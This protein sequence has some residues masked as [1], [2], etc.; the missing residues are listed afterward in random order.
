M[1][2][3]SGFCTTGAASTVVRDN[4]PKTLVVVSTGKGAI[5]ASPFTVSSIQ[6]LMGGGA[7]IVDHNRAPNKAVIS[8]D[9]G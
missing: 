4:I 2:A 9:R 5:A 3:G 8:S 1:L 6:G 7:T